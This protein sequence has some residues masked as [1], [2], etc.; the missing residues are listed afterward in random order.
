[1][2]DLMQVIM[3]LASETWA[4]LI[5][6]FL[7][8]L[9]LVLLAHTIRGTV[10]VGM[11]SGAGLGEAAM[12]LIGPLAVG[13]FLFLGVPPLLKTMTKITSC[14]G[15]FEDLTLWAQRLLAVL[16]AFRMLK[17]GYLA[18]VAEAIGTGEAAAMLLNEAAGIVAAMLFIPFIGGVASTLLGC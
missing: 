12:G 9:S 8:V 3:A 7:I 11:G 1:M 17:I 18:I 5:T 2:N 16:M 4:V 13:L 6:G 15:T 10:A 14:T